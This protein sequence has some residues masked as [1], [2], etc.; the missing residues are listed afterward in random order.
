MTV[1]GWYRAVRAGV[2]AAVC[3]LLA[4]LA[5]ATMSGDPVP[6]WAMGTGAAVTGA[7][8]W[9]LAGRER[10]RGPIVVVVTAVQALLHEGFSLAQQ[11]ASTAAQAGAHAMSGHA[12]D[13]RSMN[14]PSMDM[15]SMG[16][17]VGHS[18]AAAQAGSTGGGTDMAVGAHGMT[19]LG[20][21]HG[22]TGAASVGMFSAHL[23]ASLLCGLWLAH[24][25]R[26][27]F[28]V[29]RAAAAWLVAPLRLLLALPAPAHRPSVR[30]RRPAADAPVR[31]LL[32][33]SLT[34]RGPP[35]AAA[36]A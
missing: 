9:V 1:R 11:A 18:A 29:L 19:G 27:V 5:H 24:G 34:F 7:A 28:R 2:F 31:R 10:G 16:A 30:R 20:H 15:R 21:V 8:G 17:A 14:M 26:G 13:M 35:A 6:W 22:M 36:V 3:V 4:A 23:L 32:C 25:E 33:A 12:M